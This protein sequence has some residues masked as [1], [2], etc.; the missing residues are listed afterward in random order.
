MACRSFA[1]RARPMTSPGTWGEGAVLT[2]GPGT[3]SAC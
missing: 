2:L 1:S 3:V